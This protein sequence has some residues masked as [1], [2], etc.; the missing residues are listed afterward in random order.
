MFQ[1]ANIGPIVYSTC[2]VLRPE[3]KSAP[4]IYCVLAIGCLASF[5][6]ALFWDETS[7]IGGELHSTALLILV[8]FLALVDC[9][10]SVLYLP[11]MALWKNI[12]LPFYSVGEGLSG[13]VPA[14]VALAQGVGNSNDF[15]NNT[16]STLASTIVMEGIENYSG[17]DNSG[18]NFSVTVFFFILFGMMVAS[19]LAFV[20]L[21]NLPFIQTERAHHNP[22]P[23][24]TSLT[25]RR[26]SSCNITN[27]SEP[28]KNISSISLSVDSHAQQPAA[29]IQPKL[30]VVEHV[31]HIE[32]DSTSSLIHDE[33]G[34]FRWPKRTLNFL[35]LTQLFAG[36]L[37]NGFLPS[38]QSYSC[39]PY[40]DT[41][42]HLS[43]TLSAFANPLAAVTTALVGR[44]KPVVIAVMLSVGTVIGMYIIAAAAM[45]PEPPLV[46]TKGGSTMIV[47][48]AKLI[49]NNALII[50][51]IIL[52]YNGNSRLY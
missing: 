35:L 7:Y 44:A 48:T 8:F 50:Q 28:S 37:S 22:L 30:S 18:P 10:S 17:S 11:Y 51:R 9:T 38:I 20:L 29:E 16:T 13:L 5:F 41:A 14:L 12:Y 43:A 49:Q 24:F 4:F 6:L 46:G 47:S 52:I 45:S 40:G 33:N 15:E 26:Y 25:Q 27:F 34:S 36:L 1:I 31:P 3:A 39:G 32:S 19:A 42:Y 23:T 21:D 2:K